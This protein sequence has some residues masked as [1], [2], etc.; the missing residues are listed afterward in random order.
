M[1]RATNFSN[2]LTHGHIIRRVGFV[3]TTTEQ[4]IIANEV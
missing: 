1:V 4:K 3:V 2:K